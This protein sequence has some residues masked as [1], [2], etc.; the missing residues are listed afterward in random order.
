MSS[1]EQLSLVECRAGADEGDQMGC[2][3]GAPAGLGGVDQLVGHGNSGV[4]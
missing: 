2:V 1:F 4:S 3:Y